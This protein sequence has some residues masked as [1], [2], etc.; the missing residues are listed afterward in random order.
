MCV[1]QRMLCFRCV[2][3][4]APNRIIRVVVRGVARRKVRR[5]ERSAG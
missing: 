2:V 3:S 1:P 4:G 5:R